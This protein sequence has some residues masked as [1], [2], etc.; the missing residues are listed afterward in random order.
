MNLKKYIQEKKTNS[1]TFKGVEVIIKDQI[2]QDVSVK[3]VLNTLTS[4]VPA[5]LLLNFN[6]LYI[7]DFKQMRDRQI[8]AYYS[9]KSI[10]I[11]NNLKN[12]EDLLDDLIHEIS[13][14][15]EKQYNELI[16][17]DKK[18]EKE[19]LIKR[20][21]MWNQLKNNSIELPLKYFLN[22][23]YDVEF[24][25]ILYKEIGYTVLSAVTSNIFYSPYAATSINE[26][27][28]NGFEAFFMGEDITRLKNTSPELFTKIVKLLE[29]ERKFK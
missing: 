17:G 28:A 27:F 15:L 6:K 10:Y 18:V 13:H 12:E 11:T 19:F 9:N 1:F 5:H 26:Y 8:Q 20:K 4:K 25:E 24:D 21:Q 22:A 29:S 16:Y 23:E 14:S 2:T 3:S 7:G